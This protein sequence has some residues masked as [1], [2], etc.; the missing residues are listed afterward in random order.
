TIDYLFSQTTVFHRD[1]AAA[2]K[3]G[4]D[5]TLALSE[6][7]GNPHH[8]L[9]CI[10]IA[11]TNGK[12]ST[13]SMLAAI[14]QAAGLKV[15]LYTS[16]HLVDFRER[17]RVNGQMIP[18]DEVVSFVERYLS[19][20]ELT[21][22]HPSFFEL[23]TIMA[24]DWF[25]R[26]KVD[27]A[28][29]EV[30][31]GG[32]LDS[33]NIITPLAS[34]ITNISLDHTGLLGDTIEAIAAEKAGIIKPGVPVVIGPDMMPE[35]KA[36]IVNKAASVGA[37]IYQADAS[38]ADGV[39]C[40]LKGEFQRYNVATVLKTIEILPFEINSSAIKE[41]IAGV[42]R[43]T[44]LR[45]RL[46]VLEGQPCRVIYDT[47]HNPGAWTY[48]SEF[49]NTETAKKR[50]A[51]IG[52]ATDKDVDSILAMLPKEYFYVFTCPTGNRGLA[53]DNLAEMASKHG[54]AGKTEPY[55]ANAYD[56]ATKLAGSNGF[57]FVGGS[58][59]VVAD[60]L[61]AVGNPS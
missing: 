38:D 35:A 34:V 57:V 8:S 47:G 55:V 58:N 13:S 1:G 50:I 22:R 29:I 31:L 44:G 37:P 12:G 14:A 51:V 43:L 59:F 40:P 53:A 16:P 28:I 30:G 18:E 21:S 56:R 42:T 26:Q 5:T 6:A 7:F 46:T 41:G 19:R 27:L 52:F 61:K 25:N 54:L 23:T 9:R 32:R 3:P 17:M 45:G 15:G 11:G 2:Y 36:V 49:L 48:I 24:L 20:Q 4:L 39:T 60:L 10:H 33:T